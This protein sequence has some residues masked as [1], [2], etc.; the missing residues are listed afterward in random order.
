MAI[1]FRSFWVHD[2]IVLLAILRHLLIDFSYKFVSEIYLYLT[3]SKISKL[4]KLIKHKNL[5]S[6]YVELKHK[7][8]IDS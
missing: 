7:Q 8:T 1:I 6:I 3:N 5:S 4:E 2:K